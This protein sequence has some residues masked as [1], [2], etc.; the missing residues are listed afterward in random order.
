MRMVPL[1]ELMPAR[2]A[3]LDPRNHPDEQFDLHSIPAHDRGNPDLALGHEIGSSKQIVQPGDVVLSKIVPHIRRAGVIGESRGR[4]QIASGE[5]IVMRHPDVE[6]RYLRSFLL[7]DSFHAKFMSTV[8]GVG[9][10]L[11]RARPAQVKLI[12]VPLPSIEEQGRIA[13]ILDQSVDIRDTRRRHLS[14]L[15]TLVQSVFDNMFG[16]PTRPH[17][18]HRVMPLGATSTKFSDGPFG[19]NL[20]S[21]HYVLEGV[22]VVRLQNIKPGMYDDTDRAYIS[23]EHFE[24]LRK[25]E[26]LPGDILIATMGEP[27]IRACIQPEYLPVALNKADCVQMRVAPKIATSEY[28]VALLNHPGTMALAGAL[29]SGQTRS[30]VSMGRLRDLHVPVPSLELQERFSE[31]VHS[32]QRERRL[33]S[34]HLASVNKLFASLQSRAF[35]GEL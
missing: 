34:E 17:V 19:S 6:P 5:W 29:V 10:S 16:S 4:R 2:A 25:H 8:A 18:E 13:A 3:S 22:P 12:E 21:E 30:R 11:M 35:R 31:I 23:A 28:L 7:S 1:G 33:A 26:C 9:G 14:Y 15:D 24:S 27:N 20:K 32:I